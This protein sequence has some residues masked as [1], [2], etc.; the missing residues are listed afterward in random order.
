MGSFI[1]VGFWCVGSMNSHNDLRTDFM[2]FDVINV[3]LVLKL[4]EI[5]CIG[6]RKLK[7]GDEQKI[8]RNCPCH[9]RVL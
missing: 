7:G 4:V 1:Y 3:G 6:E 2:S 8:F 5:S 9:F